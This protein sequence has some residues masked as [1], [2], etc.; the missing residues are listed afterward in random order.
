VS[1]DQLWIS[2]ERNRL[3]ATVSVRN[4]AY[5]KYV[6]C[7]YTHDGWKTTHE[8]AG[9]YL[10]SATPDRDTFALTIHLPSIARLAEGK[11]FQLCF[12]YVVAGDEFWDNNGGANY[13]VWLHRS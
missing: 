3:L 1:L 13:I 5:D 11:T 4:L 12:H 9:A 10:G 7:R 8:V 2:D 6:C